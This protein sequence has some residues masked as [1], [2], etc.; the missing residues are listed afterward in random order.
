MRRAA[1]NLIKITVDCVCGNELEQQSN[2]SVKQETWRMLIM[3]V[4]ITTPYFKH[5]L[6]L[7]FSILSRYFLISFVVNLI[8]IMLFDK[9][10]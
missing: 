10:I 7:L 6:P 8:S 5:R 4:F 9:L 1:H 2:G 3:R